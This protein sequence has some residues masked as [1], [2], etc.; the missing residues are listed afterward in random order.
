MSYIYICNYTEYIH[1]HVHIY[2]LRPI[3]ET[4]DGPIPAMRARQPFLRYFLPYFII[5]L[6]FWK[7]DTGS[8]RMYVCMYVVLSRVNERKEI[9]HIIEIHM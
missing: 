9:D 6:T 1:I 2:I 7:I 3:N 4:G 8:V 5:I